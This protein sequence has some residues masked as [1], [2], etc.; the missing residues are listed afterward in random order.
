MSRTARVASGVIGGVNAPPVRMPVVA[1]GS[2]RPLQT[3]YLAPYGARA[4]RRGAEE[5]VPNELLVSRELARVNGMLIRAHLSDIQVSAA[6]RM[7]AGPFHL[8]LAT[9]P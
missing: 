2:A 4:G 6:C 8:A 7:P 5:N 9:L 3:A 1:S